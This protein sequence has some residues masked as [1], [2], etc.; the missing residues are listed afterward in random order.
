MQHYNKS[1]NYAKEYLYQQEEHVPQVQLKQAEKGKRLVNYLFDLLTLS[2]FGYLIGGILAQIIPH[3]PALTNFILSLANLGKLGDHV[4]TI[5]GML[6]YYIGFESAFGVTFG[7]IITKTKVVTKN[8]HQPSFLHIVGRTL[9]R[10]IP[11]DQLSFLFVKNGGWHDIVSGTAVV[12]NP[13]SKNIGKPLVFS[14]L[15]LILGSVFFTETEGLFTQQGNSEKMLEISYAGVRLKYPDNWT[16]ETQALDDDGFSYELNIEKQGKDAVEI[17]N[18]VILHEEIEIETWLQQTVELLREEPDFKKAEFS[19]I[20]ST[21]FQE[22]NAFQID[23]KR[24]IFSDFIFGKMTVFTDG[25]LSILLL[26]HSDSKRKLEHLFNFIEETFNFETYNE[27][28][29]PD[30]YDD[31]NQS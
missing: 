25:Y 14:I 28:Y 3:S 24:K 30:V 19:T 17:A 27:D 10:F 4:F 6:I 31:L 21:R 22:F 9:C 7:K 8:G 2:L 16:V 20:Y 26:R 13:E 12:E 5:I 11:F 29:M 18:F 15:I 1:D 23:F